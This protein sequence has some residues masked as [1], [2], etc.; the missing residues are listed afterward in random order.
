MFLEALAGCILNTDF[1]AFKTQPVITMIIT[2]INPETLAS[3]DPK[4]RAAIERTLSNPNEFTQLAKIGLADF[5][6]RLIEMGH[7]HFVLMDAVAGSN[8]GIDWED[9]ELNNPPVS[10]DTGFKSFPKLV[11]DPGIGMK[12]TIEQV[13]AVLHAQGIHGWPRS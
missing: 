11:A 1:P 12:A 13:Y 4:L 6:R 9:G 5:L 2:D 10:R 8:T 7:G 3:I